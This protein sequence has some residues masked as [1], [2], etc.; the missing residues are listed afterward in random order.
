M[1]WTIKPDLCPRGT[2]RVPGDKSIAHRALILGALADGESDLQGLP[3]GDDVASTAGCL[4]QL[5][6]A[7]E[8]AGDRALIRG[9]GLKGLRGPDTALDC[10]NSGTS[11]R[12]LAG[13]LAAQPFVSTLDGDASLRSRPMERIATPLRTMGAD[14]TPTGGHA[15]IR[16][17]GA[18]LRGVAY[19]SPVPSA[20]VKSCVLLAALYASGTTTVVE[21]HGTRDHTERMLA[22]M[23][24]AVNGIAHEGGVS[25][26]AP[27]RL[28]PLAG[29]IP[30]DLSSATYWLVAGAQT[31]GADLSVSGVGFNPSRAAVVEL[32]RE[33]GADLSVAPAPAWHG[34][35]VATLRIRGRD[36]ALSGGRIE[37]G[38]TAALIDEI[39]AL[40]LLAAHSREGFTVRDAA[41]LRFKE[42][43]RIA[44]TVAAILALGGEASAT[45]DGLVVPGGQVLRGGRV[46][47]RGDHRIALAAAAISPLVAGTVEIDGAGAAAVSYPDFLTE[48]RA[49]GRQT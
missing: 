43:D 10:G 3:A 29:T 5:G 33:W 36:G 32:L 1:R 47:A 13:V 37:G 17:E 27:T 35:P 49:A 44:T 48:L 25:V 38:R 19:A 23:G 41:E 31:P 39:P 6:C 21:A 15:P 40:A 14:I 20:Q 30:G 28:M 16:I 9:G 45:D 46:D 4:R 26:T 18:S 22:A 8:V 11:M 24:V 2:V 12:L 34:E 42:S 7:I